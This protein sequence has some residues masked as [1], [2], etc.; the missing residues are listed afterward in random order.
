MT[1]PVGGQVSMPTAAEFLGGVGIGLGEGHEALHP[2]L[3]RGLAMRSYLGAPVCHGVLRHEERFGVRPAE[4]LL[5]QRDL[6]LAERFAVRFGGS[7][8][9][10]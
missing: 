8:A 6:I 1:A 10:G 2:L 3:L 9:V 7:G 4:R 5:G